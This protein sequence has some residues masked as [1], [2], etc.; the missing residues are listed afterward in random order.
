MKILQFLYAKTNEVITSFN[1]KSQWKTNSDYIT[2]HVNFK[3]LNTEEA[4]YNIDNYKPFDKACSYG[5]QEWIGLIGIE[6]IEGSYFNVVG[7]P[8]DKLYKYL[9]EF[10]SSQ[11]NLP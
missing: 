3:D 10:L 7:L 8:T 4:D 1:I 9:K 2:T 5:I 6:K 11:D